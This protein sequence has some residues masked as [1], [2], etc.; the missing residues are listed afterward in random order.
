MGASAS[1]FNSS[2]PC[3]CNERHGAIGTINRIIGIKSGP[4]FPI[5]ERKGGT[6]LKSGCAYC[7]YTHVPLGHRSVASTRLDFDLGL[8][9]PPLLSFYANSTA[10]SV[11]HSPRIEDEVASSMKIRGKP[12]ERA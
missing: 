12:I 2:F 8:D 11:R 9:I 3:D 10:A 1:Q 5:M 7:G 6:V 4:R